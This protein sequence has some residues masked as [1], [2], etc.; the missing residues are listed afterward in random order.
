MLTIRTYYVLDEDQKPIAVQIPI[1]DFHRLEEVLENYGLVQ[2][3]EEVR[4]DESVS[5]EAAYDYYR[6][7]KNELEG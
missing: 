6:S 4:D 7:L 3:M 2:L 1:G 5:G